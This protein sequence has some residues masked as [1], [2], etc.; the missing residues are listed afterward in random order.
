MP[1]VNLS[2]HLLTYLLYKLGAGGGK[3][4]LMFKKA[5]KSMV[6]WAYQSGA[7]RYGILMALFLPAEPQK[8]CKN[9]KIGKFQ[10][11]MIYQFP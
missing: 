6:F 3:G 10:I 7:V 5:C 11:H 9:L 8:N 2:N 1:F 4:R